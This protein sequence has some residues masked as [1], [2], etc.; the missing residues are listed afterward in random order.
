MS[1]RSTIPELFLGGYS[2][3]ELCLGR[4]WPMESARCLMVPDPAPP[5]YRRTRACD[6]QLADSD[7]ERL[8]RLIGQPRS[9][10]LQ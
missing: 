10:P 7:T 3:V 4:E 8:R 6:S 1:V 5:L 9:G 2:P